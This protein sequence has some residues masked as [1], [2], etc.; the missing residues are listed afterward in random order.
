MFVMTKCH[1][2]NTYKIYKLVLSKCEILYCQ[3]DMIFVTTYYVVITTRVL[4]PFEPLII[5]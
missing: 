5:S 1:C 2:G 4:K 3:Y